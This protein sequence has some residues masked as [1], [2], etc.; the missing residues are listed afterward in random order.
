MRM[1]KE[2]QEK[3]AFVIKWGFFVAAVMLMV[4]HS[5]KQWSRKEEAEKEGVSLDDGHHQDYNHDHH[6]QHGEEGLEGKKSWRR[7]ATKKS[8]EG[9][10][11]GEESKGKDKREIRKKKSKTMNGVYEIS[12]TFEKLEKDIRVY[13]HNS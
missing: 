1:A 13:F 5:C 6:W 11:D 4:V 9:G 12:S 10:D 8:K 3:T 7:R 2:T